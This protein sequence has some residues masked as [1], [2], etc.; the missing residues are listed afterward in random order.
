MAL[1]EHFCSSHMISGPSQPVQLQQL[2]KDF[3]CTALTVLCPPTNPAR[4]HRQTT[5]IPSSVRC[6]ADTEFVAVEPSQ[7][8]CI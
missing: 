4:A 7:S 3:L 2:A 6:L 8:L 5:Q 1:Q